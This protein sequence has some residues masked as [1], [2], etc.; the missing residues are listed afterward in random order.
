MKRSDHVE[1][2]FVG[3]PDRRRARFVEIGAR[4][5]KLG[6]KR[7]Y[8]RVLLD[9]IS[10]G[11]HHSCRDTFAPRRERDRLPVIAARRGDDAIGLPALFPQTHVHE[12]AADL[13]GADGRVVLMLDPSLASDFG[14]EQGP[15]I[16]RCRRHRPIDDATGAF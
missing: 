15:D 4:L 5:D 7:P 13:E 10:F 6:S 1:P 8:G 11:D 16:L 2:A 3:K 12:P 14:A 9:G